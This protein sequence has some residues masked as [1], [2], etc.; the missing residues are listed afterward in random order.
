MTAPATTERSRP[1]GV[2]RR[3]GELVTGLASLTVFS[4]VLAGIPY[5]LV[6]LFGSPH[7]AAL[8]VINTDLSDT[9]RLT[10]AITAVGVILAWLLW[11]QVS[12]AFVAEVVSARQGRPS[13][14]LSVLPG[15]QQLARRIV[16][17]TTLLVGG[18]APALATSPALGVVAAA[19]APTETSVPAVYA[20]EVYS[21]PVTS[22]YATIAVTQG[23]ALW[24]VSVDVLGDG[25]SW[26]KIQSL[27]LGTRMANGERMSVDTESVPAGTV[28]RV[29]LSASVT[30]RP[31]PPLLGP[32]TMGHGCRARSGRPVSPSSSA[33]TGR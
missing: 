4:V 21:A 29:P 27:N 7:R 17:A 8:D 6:T 13:R 15:I 28:L 31:I 3:L 12:Y 32:T 9:I 25:R 11:A 23:E 2:A 30:H 33:G 18:I 16:R 20:A 19:T 26:R 24:D 5:A 22:T 1:V 14:Q 10:A